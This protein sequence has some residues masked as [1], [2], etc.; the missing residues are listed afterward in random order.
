MCPEAVDSDMHLAG[1]GVWGRAFP[2]SHPNF[3]EPKE[4]LE[5][6]WDLVKPTASKLWRADCESFIP[7]T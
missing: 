6:F 4:N 3:G 1:K 5:A 2:T 7:Q